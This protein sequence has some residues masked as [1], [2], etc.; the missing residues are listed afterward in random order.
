MNLMASSKL[1]DLMDIEVS[2]LVVSEDFTVR[3]DILDPITSNTSLL[4]HQIYP[5][6]GQQTRVEGVEG[7]I[8]RS[9]LPLFS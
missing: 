7:T 9:T 3:V 8:L 5:Y 6:Q 2:A 4:L 1:L